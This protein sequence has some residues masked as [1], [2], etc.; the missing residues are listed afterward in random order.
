MYKLLLANSPLLVLPI[1]AL[2]LFLVTFTLIVI[3]TFARRAET[4]SDEAAL[5]LADDDSPVGA[6]DVTQ[7]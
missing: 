4:Y 7:E 3:R 2:V 6:L 1:F 5:P